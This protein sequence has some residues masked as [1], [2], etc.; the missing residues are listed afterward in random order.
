VELRLKRKAEK[1]LDALG[2]D[3]SSAVNVF[4]KKVVATHSIPFA[5]SEEPPRY[6]FTFAEEEEILA[7]VK[8]SR[9]PKKVSGPFH[10]ADELIRHL[11]KAKA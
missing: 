8:E 9:D 10:G 2:L 11:R 6:Q 7:S 1:V 5:L 4:L 3:L